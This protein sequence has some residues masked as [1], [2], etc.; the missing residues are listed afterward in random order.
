VIY[1]F[2]DKRSRKVALVSNCIIN[3]NAKVDGYA[4]YT[5][6]VPRF[7]NLLEKYNFGIEQMPCPEIYTAGIRR[8]WQVSEQYNTSGYIRSFTFLANIVLDLIEDYIRS[9]FKVVLI[10]VDGSPTCG[11]NYTDTDQENQWMGSPTIKFKKEEDYIIK[12]EAPFIKVLKKQIY[13]R[14]L[15]EIP[16][17]GL[18]MDV[19]GKKINLKIIEKFLSKI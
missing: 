8:W 11:V 2:N 7:V 10:G 18:P 9:N 16:M 1:L 15:P 13:L 17:I 19:P 12:G 6:M 4:L 14:D 5:A 3:Q